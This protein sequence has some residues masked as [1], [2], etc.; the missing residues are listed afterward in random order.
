MALWERLWFWVTMHEMNDATRGNGLVS[1]SDFQSR[2]NQVP[3]LFDS[4]D[5][6]ASVPYKLAGNSSFLAQILGSHS[7]YLK[8]HPILWGVD[9]DDFIASCILVFFATIAPLVAQ[10]SAFSIRKSL[11]SSLDAGDDSVYKTVLVKLPETFFERVFFHAGLCLSFVILKLAVDILDLPVVA[12]IDTTILAVI[13]LKVAF[14]FVACDAIFKVVDA[15][16]QVLT[17]RYA[18]PIGL[19]DIFNSV[20][21]PLMLLFKTVLGLLVFVCV[22]GLLA[23]TGDNMSSMFMSF[24]SVCTLGAFGFLGLAVK[25]I[26]QEYQSAVDI[27]TEGL[28]KKD[29][30]IEI[31]SAGRNVR[32]RVIAVETRITR[33]LTNDGVLVTIPNNSIPCSIVVNHTSRKFTQ[34]VVE[35]M[36][37]QKCKTE[38]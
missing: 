35:L 37:S 2:A 16:H 23:R 14:F 10:K 8:G 33:I 18:E 24:I 36:I 20:T 4:I 30:E 3:G 5:T 25:G 7:V 28:F 15:C 22:A 27:I 19:V 17:E 21:S 29:D 13:M 38:E 1:E 26:A 32:G 12:G 34:V 31:Q 6:H 9:S 11:R